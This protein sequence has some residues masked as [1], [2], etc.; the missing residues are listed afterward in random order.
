MNKVS[1][2]ILSLIVM[3][4]SNVI[5][6]NSD[7]IITEIMFDPPNAIIGQAQDYYRCAN[8]S[9]CQWVEVYNRGDSAIDLSSWKVET[10]TRNNQGNYFYNFGDA[11]IQPESYLVIATQLSDEEGDGFSLATVY[12]DGD[13]LWGNPSADNFEAVDSDIPFFNTPDLFPGQNTFENIALVD[14]EGNGVSRVAFMSYETGPLIQVQKNNGYTSERDTSGK[15]LK[16]MGLGGSPGRARNSPPVFTSIPDINLSEDQVLSSRLLDFR[17]FSS[18]V[19]TSKDNFVFSIVGIDT[20][21]HN[22]FF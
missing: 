4:S 18:D 7:V 14:P 12:G 17:S 10:S 3:L 5:A 16:S 11:V 15:Y 8:D 9:S 19:E 22:L 6:A 21:I 20:N 13:G 1:W 2:I